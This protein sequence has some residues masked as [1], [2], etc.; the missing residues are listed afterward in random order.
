M[1]FVSVELRLVV[2]LQ[3]K[4]KIRNAFTLL[5][6]GLEPSMVDQIQLATVSLTTWATWLPKQ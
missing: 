5:Q 3:D 2:Q 6:A 4:K 1:E